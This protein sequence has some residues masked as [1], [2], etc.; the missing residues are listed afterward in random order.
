MKVIP[1]SVFERI[2]LFSNLPPKSDITTIRAVR[3]LRT[4]LSFTDD[5][6]KEYGIESEKDKNGNLTGRIRWDVDK[7]KDKNIEFS[8]GMMKVCVNI[9]KKFNETGEVTEQHIPLYDKFPVENLTEDDSST[10]E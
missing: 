8:T 2:F 1:L 9:L 4:D 5:E 10:K 6:L 3:Q 7:V